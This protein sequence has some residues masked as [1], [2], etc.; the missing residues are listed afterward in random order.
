MKNETKINLIVGIIVIIA[1]IVFVTI[2]TEDS[3]AGLLDQFDNKCSINKIENC[4][5]VE[6]REMLQE[7]VNE[8]N[9]KTDKRYYILEK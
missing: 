6:A 5:G 9:I 7:I 2:Q 1:T 8:L 3:L 4:S